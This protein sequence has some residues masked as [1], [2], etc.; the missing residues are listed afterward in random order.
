[1]N[2]F[3]EKYL[4]SSNKNQNIIISLG[5]K[6][7]DY[8]F[9]NTLDKTTVHKI[10]QFINETYRVKKKY[11]TENIF[12]K[13]N[14]QIKQINNELIYSIIKDADTF[15]DTDYLLKWRKYSNDSVTIPSYTN[16]DYIYNKE[17]LE[18]LIDN[19]FMC[20]IIIVDDLHSINIVVHK[21]CAIQKVLK[22]L[23]NLEEL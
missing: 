21:P 13:G 4:Q 3:L 14:E 8:I 23:K 18:L 12:Q 15:I 7:T 10:I 1:M 20:K 5:K 2:S 22:F 17:V 11:Y 16:Y 19:M 9:D 6:T